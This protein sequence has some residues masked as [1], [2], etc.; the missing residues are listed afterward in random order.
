MALVRVMVP[1][2]AKDLRSWG[3]RGIELTARAL[4]KTSTK[5]QIGW[6]AMAMAM[7]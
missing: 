2:R 6:L 1:M 5:Q 3:L 4:G 7:G